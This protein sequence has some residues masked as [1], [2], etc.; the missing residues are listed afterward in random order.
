[1]FSFREVYYEENENIV[2]GTYELCGPSIQ[3][4]FDH[5][6]CDTFVR[7]GCVV[8]NDVPRT[9][10]GIRDYLEIHQIEGIVFHREDGDMCKIKRTDFGF[11]WGHSI[12]RNK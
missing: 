4:N 5:F 9:F 1:M 10:E 11:E 8:L 2:D 12:A 3:G 6:K 7:Y